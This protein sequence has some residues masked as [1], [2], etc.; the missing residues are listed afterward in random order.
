MK[1]VEII[2]LSHLSRLDQ[3]YEIQKDTPLTEIPWLNGLSSSAIYDKKDV[4]LLLRYEEK[5]ERVWPKLL[6]GWTFIKS[7]ESSEM[8]DVDKGGTIKVGDRLISLEID[9]ADVLARVNAFL[10]KKGNEY[11]LTFRSTDSVEDAFSDV[12][13]ALFK[14]WDLSLT[15]SYLMAIDAINIVHDD[16][17]ATSLMIAGHSM[18]G[19]M[20]QYSYASTFT[21]A[22]DLEVKL[23]CNTFN[24]LGIAMDKSVDHINKLDMDVPN[25]TYVYAELVKLFKADV[26]GFD[27]SRFMKYHKEETLLAIR[28]ILNEASLIYGSSPDYATV[29]TWKLGEKLKVMFGFGSTKTNIDDRVN[30]V[31]MIK[32]MDFYI[33]YIYYT[34]ESLTNYIRYYNTHTTLTS[35]KNLIHY[36]IPEDWTTHQRRELGINFDITK[37]TGNKYIDILVT[38][39]LSMIIEALKDFSFE[40]HGLN[41]FLAYINNDGDLTPGKMRKCILENVI[42]N[43]YI[44]RRGEGIFNKFLYQDMLN[45]TAYWD[46]FKMG[47]HI[48]YCLSNIPEDKRE[49]KLVLGYPSN[50]TWNG[51]VC[52]ETLALSDINTQEKS[53]E[54]L[55]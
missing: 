36:H 43:W 31:N 28:K 39:P 37:E 17:D 44:N 40:Y 2:N 4:F 41:N 11:L 16:I 47:N 20:A 5:G 35:F 38:N 45:D 9:R 52:T 27:Y 12:N 8:F 26:G 1:H 15:T 19:A 10:F 50:F 32:N 54:V 46:S 30:G 42:Y 25:R 7:Y 51:I 6:D 13:I 21:Y 55:V 18:G 34:L 22:E 49:E 23:T 53:D 24:A 48:H 29:R 14:K 3:W 33:A